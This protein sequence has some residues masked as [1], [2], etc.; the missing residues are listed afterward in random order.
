MEGSHLG[1]RV[2]FQ[3]P[4]VLIQLFVGMLHPSHSTDRKKNPPR[5][6]ASVSERK[7]R[8]P[9]LSDKSCLS[10]QRRGRSRETSLC[11]NGPNKR[12][13]F[14]VPWQAVILLDRWEEM[15]NLFSPFDLLCSR[16]ESFPSRHQVNSCP[17]HRTSPASFVPSS[18]TCFI[19]SVVWSIIYVYFYSSAAR[20]VFV[21][22]WLP[23]T[24]ELA[25]LKNEGTCFSVNIY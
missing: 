13:H 3:R 20:P 19:L 6:K 25:P 10:K 14:V 11:A 21:G 5:S 24:W 12:C 4:L 23:T 9:P 7:P 15:R 16:G 8:W 2:D 17:I 18:A 1:L 22:L